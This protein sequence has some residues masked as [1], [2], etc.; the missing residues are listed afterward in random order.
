MKEQEAI[1]RLKSQ[2]EAIGDDCAVIPHRGSHLVF[3]ID[4]LW[5]TTDFPNGI[6]PYTIGWRAVAVS[7][8]DIAAMG[9]APL[10]VVLALGAREF[11]PHFLDEV[12]RGGLD[13]CEAVNAPY[14]GGDLSKHDS[15]TLTSSAIGESANPVLRSGAKPGDLVCVTGALGRTALAMHLFENKDDKSIASANKLFQ[16]TPR[17]REGLALNEIA[18]SMMD[19]SDGLA[20]SLHQ[21][22]QASA[23][24]FRIE[25]DKIP[26][27]PMFSQSELS[28]DQFYEMSTFTGEDFELLFTTSADKYAEI[29]TQIDCA[30]IGTVASTEDGIQVK[31]KDGVVTLEDRGYEHG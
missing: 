12:L 19:I 14:V 11:E 1:Q 21:L 16:F 26:I 7:L 18:S 20:R 31:G 29:S 3:T 6:T 22:G 4:M 24:G 30:C 13:C 17:V 28:N 8:S 23:V 2:V 25:R 9:A 10:G 27:D 15:L 5:E